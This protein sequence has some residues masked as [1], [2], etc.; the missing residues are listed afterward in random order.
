M[1]WNPLQD[2]MLLQERMNRL[3]EDATQRRSRSETNQADDLDRADWCPSADVYESETEFT[4]AI[5]LPGIDRDELK[6]DMEE[7]R[8][9]VRGERRLTATKGARNERA[10]GTF[11]RTFGVPASVDQNKINATYKD[12]VV[13]IHL[14]RRVT[15]AKQRVEIKV[16]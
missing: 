3:F 15:A 12:G 4:I 5:D 6:L 9:I 1:S 16:N 11:L 14:P 8:L 7:S 10:S 13:E 2:L